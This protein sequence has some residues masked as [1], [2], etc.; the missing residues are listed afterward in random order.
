[1]ISV[2]R[3]PELEPRSRAI[4]LTIAWKSTPE[5]FMKITP[6]KILVDEFGSDVYVKLANQKLV[7]IAAVPAGI[8]L[9]RI[10]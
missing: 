6:D 8:M 1:M 10:V 7:P 9:P 5:D 4:F 2:N 3:W